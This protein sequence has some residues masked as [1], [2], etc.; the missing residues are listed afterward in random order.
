MIQLRPAT[1]ADARTI[2]RKVLGAGLDPTSLDWRRFVLAV[3]GETGRVVGCAQIK[4]HAD[5]D[6]FGSLV[7]DESMRGRGIGAR[8]L[9]HL[10]ERAEGALYLICLQKMQTYYERFGFR[11][12]D[13]PDMPRT[14]RI[15]TRAGRIFGLPVLCMRLVRPTT[16]N[17]QP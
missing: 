10:L 7:V 9:S 12:L 6:E 8:L 1:R 17:A 14:L 2:L 3:D 16:L 11:V 15:K 5:C 4:R 13:L